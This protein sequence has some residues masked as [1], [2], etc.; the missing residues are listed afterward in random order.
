MEQNLKYQKKRNYRLITPCCGKSNKDGKFVNYKDI[1]SNLDIVIAVVKPAF[2][3]LGQLTDYDQIQKVNNSNTSSN[4]PTEKLL[5]Q[6]VSKQRFIQER[7]IWN[8]FQLKPENN[9]IR[10][11][12]KTYNNNRVNETL[13]KYAIGSCKDGGTVFWMINEKH[14][15]QKCKVAFYNHKWQKNQSIQGTL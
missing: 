7:I 8:Y 10:Y 9:L 2:P 14:Q 13:E 4:Y 11:L 3:D 1:P 15:V 6:H 12:R 5:K